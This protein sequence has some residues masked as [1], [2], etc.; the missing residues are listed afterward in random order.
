MSE[1]VDA[2]GTDRLFVLFESGAAKYRESSSAPMDHVR[3]VRLNEWL[4]AEE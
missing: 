1:G 4:W 2:D 3:V